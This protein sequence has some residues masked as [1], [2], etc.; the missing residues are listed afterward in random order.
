[1]GASHKRLR[2]R[3]PG[4]VCLAGRPRPALAQIASDIRLQPLPPLSPS[5]TFRVGGALPDHLHGARV[6]VTLERSPASLP[7]D[8]QPLPQQP[9]AQRDGMML[10]NHLLRQP[11]RGR[12]EGGDGEEG[13][14]EMN[15]QAP[16]NLPWPGLLL[17][18]YAHT[19]KHESMVVERLSVTRP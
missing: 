17:R 13:A 16:A 12:P 14:F 18:V 8:L 9:G 1:M 10:K 4:N 19:D 7:D 6:R 2:R 15:L 3:T 5:K 11:L